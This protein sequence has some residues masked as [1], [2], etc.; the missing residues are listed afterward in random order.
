MSAHEWRHAG[1]EL[2]L[3]HTFRTHTSTSDSRATL[4]VALHKDGV[5]GIGEGAPPPRYGESIQQAL[6]WAG[7]YLSR[8]EIPRLPSASI[9]DIRVPAVPDCRAL[10]MAADLALH[11]WLAKARRMPLHQIVGVDPRLAPPT[12]FTIGIDS[13]EILAERVRDGEGFAAFKVKL[14]G[15]NDEEALRAVRRI[16]DKPIRVDANEG[17]SPDDALRHIDFC[18]EL[19]VELVEQPLPQGMLEETERLRERS[20]LPIYADEDVR[21]VED[22]ARIRPAYD[23]VNVKLVKCGG[24]RSAIE[25]IREARRHEMSVMLGCGIESSVGIS[26]A[27]QIAPLADYADIDGAILIANDPATGLR[28]EKGR[29]LPGPGSGLCVTIRDEDL[30][31]ALTAS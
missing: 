16:T 3:R 23:G 8:L 1:F 29:L 28:L 27:A 31:R 21:T 13:P 12:S 30:A 5:V 2:R 15:P 6:E 9:D 22:I 10:Q 7:D 26:A 25:S 19:G 24:L 14:G 18:A 17:W 11:D 20:P 4:Y